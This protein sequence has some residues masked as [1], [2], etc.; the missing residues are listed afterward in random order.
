M[1]P[2]KKTPV[3]LSGGAGFDFE[4]AIAA[5]F[6]L[7][8]LRGEAV[9]G[10]EQGTSM[11]LDFQ[12]GETG[13]LLDDLLLTSV[14]H[15]EKLGRAAISVKTAKQITMTGGFDASFR[16]AVWAQ[17]AGATAGPFDKERD[18]LCL[19]TANVADSVSKAWHELQNEALGTS[20]ERF[21]ERVNSATQ[22]SGNIRCC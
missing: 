4:D 12:V 21:L 5:R 13:W 16:D 20:T 18:L 15:Q 19:A 11:Q 14:N 6:L 3:Q 7:S 1:V 8:M 2:P 9:F 10:A 22:T 17:W